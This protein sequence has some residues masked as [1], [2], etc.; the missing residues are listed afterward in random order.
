MPLRCVDGEAELAAYKMTDP[1]WDELRQKNSRFKHLKMHCCDAGVTLKTSSLGT[2]FFAHLRKGECVTQPETAE[3]LFA[4]SLVASALS[5][6]EWNARTEVSGETSEGERWVA[7]V[8]AEKGEKRVAIEIQWSPQSLEETKRR[9]ARYKQ[10]RVRGL[11]LL[12]RPTQLLIEQETP[13]FL[14]VVDVK[15]K[16]AIVKLPSDRFFGL[17]NTDAKLASDEF[18]SQEVELH[19]FVKG[20]LNGA[21]KWAPGLNEVIPVEL[22]VAYQQC[23]KCQKSTTIVFSVLFRVDLVYP[24]ARRVAVRLSQFDSPI[25]KKLLADALAGVDLRAHGIGQIKDRY[26]RS[27]GEAYLSNGCVHCDA[28]QGAFYEH[29]A[30]FSEQRVPASSCRMAESLFEDVSRIGSAEY[31]WFDQ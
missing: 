15:E 22:E 2:K 8:L 31:W 25:E 9:Q 4:K 24:G 30:E 13:A 5:G 1:E 12:R 18:W 19:T 27:V 28:L 11:W 29:E 23:W 16:R 26:S 21:L 7:D 17:L 3:H 20:A 10:S 14:L 6:T